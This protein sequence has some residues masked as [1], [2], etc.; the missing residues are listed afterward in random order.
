MP[1]LKPL[2]PIEELA[3]VL[4]IADG[5]LRWKKSGKPAGSRR[6]DG[7][8]DLRAIGRRMLLHRVV[9]A[10]AYG[11]DPF[12]HF[13]D[14]VDGDPSNNA[15]HNLRLASHTENLRNSRRLR[16]N[17]VSGTPGVRHCE[18]NG[19]LYW[20]AFIG[21]NG[22]T[23]YLGAYQSKEAAIAAREVAELFVFGRFSRLASLPSQSLLSSASRTAVEPLPI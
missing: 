18:V 14:H 23:L 3:A 11:A 4:E 9:Y 12:P 21:I 13:V 7:Y 6:K 17:N 16:R 1:S 10:L 19:V 20:K 2:P 5:G 8:W 22:K 15:P